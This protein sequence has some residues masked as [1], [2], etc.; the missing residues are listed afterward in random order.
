[1]SAEVRCSFCRAATGRFTA[2]GVAI[3]AACVEAHAATLARARVGAERAPL[4]AADASALRAALDVRVVGQPEAQ[5]AVAAALLEHGARLRLGLPGRAP[6]LLLVGPRGSG[7]TTL[8]RAMAELA[9]WP[10]VRVDAGRLGE[11][12]LPSESV[13]LLLG[14]LLRAADHDPVRAAQG[15][16]LVDGLD[17]ASFGPERTRA[18]QRELLRLVDGTTGEAETGARAS[19]SGRVELPT[20]G[21]LVVVAVTAARL[22]D[23]LGLVPAFAARFDRVVSLAPLDAESLSRLV[24]RAVA[25]AGSLLASGGGLQLAPEAVRWIVQHALAD[26]DGGWAALRAVRRLVAEA[27]DGSRGRWRVSE[28]DLARLYAGGGW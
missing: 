2:E 23:A 21:V 27:V 18:V 28:A 16:V 5:K 24:E 4:Y 19:S 12:G 17:P 3:C 20:E 22:E 25:Q 13:E 14:S 10:S 1:M 26:P 9:A 15:A 11:A 7:K 8:A 6:R